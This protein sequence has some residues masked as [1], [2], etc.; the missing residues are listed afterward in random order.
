MKIGSPGNGPSLG[1]SAG[2][3]RYRKPFSFLPKV[4]IATAIS[5]E[6][7]AC[8]VLANPIFQAAAWA[9]TTS[10]LWNRQMRFVVEPGKF[11]LMIGSSSED[12]R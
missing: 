2:K 4:A 11:R 8:V 9:A 6:I 10:S 3:T 5:T 7:A 1:P 12:I